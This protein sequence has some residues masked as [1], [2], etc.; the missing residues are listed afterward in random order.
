MRVLFAGTPAP[1]LPTAQML[2]DSE[3]VLVGV[4]TKAD[5]PTGRGRKLSPCPVKAFAE[6]H[7]LPYFTEKPEGQE[8]LDFIQQTKPDVIVVVAYGHLIKDEYL[9]VVQHGWVN[10]HFSLLPALRGAAPVQWAIIWGE[11]LTGATT[12]KISKGI[13]TG[14]IYGTLTEVIKANDTSGE[15]L[16]RLSVS[17]AHLM[18][19]TLQALE[20]G[21]LIGQ[22][23]SP[24]GI[25]YAP[26]ITPADTQ[27]RWDLPAA[28][29]DR[30]I[31]GAHPAPGAWSSLGGVRIGVEPISLEVPENLEKLAPGELLVT[32]KTVYV[33]CADR[34]IAL[35]NIVPKGKK[36][37]PAADWA[38]GAH[39]D[40]G[41]RF[42][43]PCNTAN[44][45]APG[46]K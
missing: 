8:F 17:G 24:D 20:S 36:S 15:L 27:I 4:L 28:I 26:K 45:Q 2:L 29:I 35:Q 19:K 5:A 6:E 33:G 7:N 16:G 42:D 9:E 31:R 10:L 25:S 32:K 18:E 14:E 22:K 13:D 41:T 44:P 40:A 43:P 21:Q 34:N 12:F 30:L 46:A 3:H 39:L 38:R 37:M 11:T 1:A 23:Q